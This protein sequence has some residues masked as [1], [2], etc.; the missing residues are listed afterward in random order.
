MYL[1]FFQPA[2]FDEDGDMGGDQVLRLY[3]L[4]LSSEYVSLIVQ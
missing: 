3:I 1:V 4:L 2:L